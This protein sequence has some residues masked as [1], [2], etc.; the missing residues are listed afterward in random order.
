MLDVV[1]SSHPVSLPLSRLLSR[2]LSAKIFRSHYQGATSYAVPTGDPIRDA[3]PRGRGAGKTGPRTPRR[4]RSEH[5]PGAH[6]LHEPAAVTPAPS[7]N[8]ERLSDEA[9][10]YGLP[11]S[12]TRSEAPPRAIPEVGGRSVDAET[13]DR[14]LTRSGAGRR[15]GA[16]V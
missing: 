10:A 1:P 9:E 2:K 6:A 12:L 13:Q 5:D 8:R 7:T 15:A 14:S 11:G 3:S 16:P 4:P